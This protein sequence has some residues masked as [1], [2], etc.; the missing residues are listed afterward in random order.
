MLGMSLIT[1]IWNNTFLSI[2][3]SEEQK[4]SLEYGQENFLKDDTIRPTYHGE[5]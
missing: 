3:R 2:W 1:N 5:Y 4:F